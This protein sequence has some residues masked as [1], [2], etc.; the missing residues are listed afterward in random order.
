MKDSKSNARTL[1]ALEKT[2][3]EHCKYTNQS[4]KDV[5]REFGMSYVTLYRKLHPDTQLEDSFVKKLS[6]FL[7]INKEGILTLHNTNE[8]K[9]APLSTETQDGLIKPQKRLSYS[10]I[11]LAMIFLFIIGISI[12]YF[13]NSSSKDSPVKDLPT[14]QALYE[15]TAKDIDLSTTTFIPGFHSKLYDYKFT[16]LESNIQGENIS[17][18]GEVMVRSLVEENTSYDAKLAASGIYLGGKAALSYKMTFEATGEAWNG[19]MMFDLELQS[20]S[21]GYWLTMHNM[22]DPKSNGKFALGDATLI[23]REIKPQ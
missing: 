1:S 10:S 19:V 12:T 22:A 3:N 6:E 5:A 11:S 20:G 23:R 15:G 7:N 14:Y 21:T 17:L 4:K 2:F 9:N 18:T 13:I 8:V 16:N